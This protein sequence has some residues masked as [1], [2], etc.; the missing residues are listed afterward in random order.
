MERVRVSSGHIDSIGYITES[1]ILEVKFLDGSIYH[2]YGVGV[3][4]FNSLMNA[5]SHG[6]FLNA[7]IKGRYRYKRI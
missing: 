6:T 7:Y 5:K 3:D 2:Y 4:I 1:S